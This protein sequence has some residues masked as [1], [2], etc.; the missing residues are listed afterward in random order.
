MGRRPARCY[1]YIGNKPYPKSRF[2]RGVPDPRIIRYETGTKTAHAKDLPIC[3]R[4][5]LL[6][7]ECVSSEALEAS[8]VSS[9]RYMMKTMGKDGY[10]I[11]INLHP[12]HVLRINKMLST[13]GA[14][15][16]QTGMRHA[17]GKPE[18]LVARANYNSQIMTIRTTSA[19]LKH[20][21]EALRRASFKFPGHTRVVISNKV[22]FTPYTFEE[23]KEL[24]ANGAI[25]DCGNHVKRVYRR[26]PIPRA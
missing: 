1:R 18:G 2:C 5:I 20:A 4:L 12:F 15:R 16:L 14:D 7:H 9:N 13:A 10:H 8:R 17:F 25:V 22:G 26:G 19:G 21:L 24:Q 11:K 3:C 23:F 6:E